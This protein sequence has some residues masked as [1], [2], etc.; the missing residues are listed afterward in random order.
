MEQAILDWFLAAV[1][2]PLS[3]NLAWMSN[4]CGP[5]Q[6]SD[7]VVECFTPKIRKPIPKRI[8]RHF[9]IFWYTHRTDIS[10]YIYHKNQLNVGKYTYQFMGVSRKF[11][12][13]KWPRRF[14]LAPSCLTPLLEQF[15]RGLGPNINIC[16]LYKVYMGLTIKEPPIQNFFPPFSLRANSEAIQ[17]VA[18]WLWSMR[19]FDEI[20]KSKL[21][22]T[23][24]THSSLIRSIATWMKWMDLRKLEN[25]LKVILFTFYYSKALL[26]HDWMTI[27]DLL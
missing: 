11:H 3:P 26:N 6:H 25:C 20:S 19:L 17:K 21:L 18:Q 23:A 9:S 24:A 16:P 7:F 14:S 12:P 5:I 27:Y 15:K 4:L 1:P 22:P 8:R 13:T 2:L 10:L